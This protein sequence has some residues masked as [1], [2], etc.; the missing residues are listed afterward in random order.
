ML[1]G[2]IIYITSN[3]EVTY[4]TESIN[5]EQIIFNMVYR[6]MSISIYYVA[7]ADITYK[8]LPEKHRTYG[9]GLFQFLELLE[10][11]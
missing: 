3:L 2:L 6:G 9:A 5:I 10:L 4:W 11:V 7:L 1:L 8:T